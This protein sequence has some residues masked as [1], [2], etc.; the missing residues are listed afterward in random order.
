MFN[1]EADFYDLP[2]LFLEKLSSFLPPCDLLSLRATDRRLRGVA[3]WNGYKVSLRGPSIREDRYEFLKTIRITEL[4]LEDLT[5]DKIEGFGNPEFPLFRPA[6]LHSLSTA[7]QNDA[8]LV[9][10]LIKSSENVVSLR[11]IF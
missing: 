11:S 4:S 1:A 7:G 3:N 8:E 10:D 5:R 6:R 2:E 9:F